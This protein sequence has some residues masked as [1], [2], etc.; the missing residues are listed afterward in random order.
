M[1]TVVSSSDEDECAEY[2]VK[3]ISNRKEL[4]Q[5]TNWRVHKIDDAMFLLISA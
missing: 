4:S 3:R 1:L 2:K 5:F